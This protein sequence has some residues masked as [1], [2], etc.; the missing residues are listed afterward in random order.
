MKRLLVTLVL[1]CVLVA[2]ALA[3]EVPTVGVT[4]PTP[5]RTTSDRARRGAFL[6]GGP[7]N[8]N[9]ISHLTAAECSVSSRPS[10][11]FTEL[12]SALAKLPTLFP[13]P[14][15]GQEIDFR[16]GEL[17]KGHQLKH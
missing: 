1:T 8:S 15:V 16:H 5:Q 13:V 10:S 14:M 2:S 9:K 4:A 17:Y 3:G 6:L 11:F 7:H 12:S